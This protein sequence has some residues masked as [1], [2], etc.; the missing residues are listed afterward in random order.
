MLLCSS[1]ISFPLVMPHLKLFHI[2]ESYLW[3]EEIWWKVSPV[4]QC[5]P[6]ML[7]GASS[8]VRR[9][10]PRNT[11]QLSSVTREYWQSYL[12]DF[13]LII[14]FACFDFLLLLFIILILLN[15]F[16]PNCGYAVRGFL[17]FTPNYKCN[18]HWLI[19]VLRY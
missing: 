3:C 13:S 8:S 14:L 5:L 19:A 15:L 9:W 18:P 7:R 12:E 16:C 11:S 6:I 2:R 4:R 17:S 1:V 10:V